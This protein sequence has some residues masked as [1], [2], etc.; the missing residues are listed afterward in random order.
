MLR[1]LGKLLR[2]GGREAAGFVD[3][4]EVD[5]TS[6]FVETQRA[7]L[8]GRAHHRDAL[9]ALEAPGAFD[10]RQADHRAQ[11]AATEAGMLR[12]SILSAPKQQ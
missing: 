7:W 1:A 10:Q 9:V 11:L 3:V 8:E 12:R 4:D 6:A 5:V 2:P